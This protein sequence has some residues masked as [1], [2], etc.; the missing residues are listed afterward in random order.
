MKE[1]LVSLQTSPYS[2]FLNAPLQ[3][4]GRFMRKVGFRRGISPTKAL[5]VTHPF[6][7]GRYGTI[8]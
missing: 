6:L 5:I 3:R 2:I 4:L 8:L 1:I 7:K